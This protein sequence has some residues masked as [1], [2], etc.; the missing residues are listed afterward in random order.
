MIR[1][2]RWLFCVLPSDKDDVPWYRQVAWAIMDILN[3]TTEAP[4]EVQLSGAGGDKDDPEGIQSQ[5]LVLLGRS[6]SSER[7]YFFA[8]RPPQGHV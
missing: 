4:G 1:M 2:A 3:L 7:S 5:I 8:T 6:C